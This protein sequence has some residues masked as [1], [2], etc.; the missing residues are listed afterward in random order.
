MRLTWV[1]GVVPFR[2]TFEQCVALLIGKGLGE[3]GSRLKR[4]D[5]P[6]ADICTN[7]P[8]PHY[9]HQAHRYSLHVN[10]SKLLHRY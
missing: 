10:S 8:L 2:V 7:S 3:I 6:G 9:S 1:F 4:G 5:S